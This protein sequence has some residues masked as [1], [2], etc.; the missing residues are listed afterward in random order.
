LNSNSSLTK[1]EKFYS[2][3]EREFL[4]KSKSLN[5]KE[6]NDI[7]K[8]FIETE[9]IKVQESYFKTFFNKRYGDIGDTLIKHSL[10]ECSAYF[11][12]LNHKNILFNASPPKDSATMRLEEII[13]NEKSK[14]NI[15]KQNQF[16]V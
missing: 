3:A 10:D 7:F 14:I 11:S 15:R 12:S 6:F 5:L 2:K 1:I 4:S 9:T 8:V 16:F 13:L